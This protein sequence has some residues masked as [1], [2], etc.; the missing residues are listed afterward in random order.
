MT[1][2][3]NHPM[4]D[5]FVRTGADIRVINGECNSI[6]I[7]EKSGVEATALITTSENGVSMSHEAWHAKNAREYYEVDKKDHLNLCVYMRKNPLYSE[8]TTARLLVAGSADIILDGFF[9]ETSDY[10]NKDLAIKSINYMSGVEDAPISVAGK[11]VIK[12]KMQRFEVKELVFM[13]AGLAG[14]IPVIMFGI[15]I[16]VYVRRRRL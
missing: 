14:A 15:G 12:E 13:I 2:M 9:D 8:D 16:V 6:E 3:Q 5:Y 10:G 1:V 7:S 11:N 4:T